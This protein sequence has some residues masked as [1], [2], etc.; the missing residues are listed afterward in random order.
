V[1]ALP[2]ISHTAGSWEQASGGLNEKY[3]A[4]DLLEN[5]TFF[6]NH[7]LSGYPLFSVKTLYISRLWLV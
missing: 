1:Q 3:R 5:V 6:F 7:I 2:L 4:S